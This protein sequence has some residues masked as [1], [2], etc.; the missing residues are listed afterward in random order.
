MIRDNMK[1]FMMTKML[2][3]D[4]IFVNPVV[5]P[6]VPNESTLIRFSLMATHTQQQIDYAIERITKVGKE[7]G[8]I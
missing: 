4:N 5:Q 3:E 6:A 8:L 7:L 2:L 1:T